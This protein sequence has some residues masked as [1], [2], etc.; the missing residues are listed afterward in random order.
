MGEG[1]GVPWVELPGPVAQQ[2]EGPAFLP[3]RKPGRPEA[4]WFSRVGQGRDWSL[5]GP[6]TMPSA[7]RQMRI[8]NQILLVTLPPLLVL[9]CGTGFFFYAYW[10]AKHNEKDI[11]RS[12]QCVAY[13]EGILRNCTEMFM[14]VRAY[15]RTRQEPN[16]P[17]YRQAA[18]EASAALSRLRDLEEEDPQHAAAVQSVTAE[19]KDWELK[20]ANPAIDAVRQNKDADPNDTIARGEEG[21]TDIRQALLGLANAEREGYLEQMRGAELT[22]RHMLF[23]GLGLAGLLAMVLIFLTRGVSRLIEEPIRQLIEASE[24]VSQG[25]FR[26]KL[27]PQVDNEFGALSRSFSNMTRVMREDREEMEALNR[28][29]DRVSQC[30]AETEVYKEIIHS[31]RD[32]FHPRQ[33]IIFTCNR[34]ESF[35][36]AKAT[37][38]DLPPEQRA[39]PTIDDMHDCKAVRTGRSFKIDDVT[40]EPPCPSHFALPT[41]GSYFCGPLIAGGNIIGSVRLECG[42]EFWTQERSQLLESYLSG[43]ASALSNLRMLETMKQQATIDPLTGLNNR[44]SLDE[45]AKHLIARSKRKEETFGIIILDLDHF[46]SFNDQY[47]HEVGDRILKVFSR[48]ITAATRETNIAARVGGEEFVVLLP[49]TDKEAAMLVA[50]RIRVAVARMVIPLSNDKTTLNVTVSAG[51]SAFPA[52]G[53]TLEEVVQAADK[54]LYESKR[55]GRNRVTLFVDRGI[56]PSEASA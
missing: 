28:F 12:A 1:L 23:M 31:L 25:N 7:I 29:A 3:N 20:W 43:A 26:P 30:R 42:K 47:G 22:M 8:R 33:I 54:A 48:T 24:L 9:L 46:K 5:S 14:V 40:D 2:A 15:I 4:G 49:D 41:E 34:G 11:A 21:L 6:T 37:M 55:N 18:A 52:H 10:A 38:T 36:E 17:P 45:L 35:L 44:R 39:W 56:P 27:P 32:R 19:I 53:E 16:L 51:V 13:S 50:E